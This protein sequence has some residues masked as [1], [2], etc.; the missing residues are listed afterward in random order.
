M[1]GSKLTRRVLARAFECLLRQEVS[2]FDKPENNAGPISIRLSTDA[3]SMQ[4][5]AGPTVSIVIEYIAMVSFGLIF[6]CLLNYQITIFVFVCVVIICIIIIMEIK[7]HSRYDKLREVSRQ[8]ENAVSS[9]PITEIYRIT[10]NTFP[11][12]FCRSD[13]RRADSEHTDSEGAH[14]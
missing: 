2:Y 12:S 11:T 1:A 10:K 14:T 13:C 5:V 7:S 6:G 3:M 4:Q 9:F 8:F